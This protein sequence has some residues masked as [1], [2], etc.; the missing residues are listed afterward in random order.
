MW[1]FFKYLTGF[2]GPKYIYSIHLLVSVYDID[3]YLIFYLTYIS[4]IDSQVFEETELKMLLKLN[5]IEAAL[6]IFLNMD[7][8]LCEESLSNKLVD[9]C[10]SKFQVLCFLFS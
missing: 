3:L 10:H 1:N 8:F 9:V 5:R 2:Y 4:R 6:I 7:Y